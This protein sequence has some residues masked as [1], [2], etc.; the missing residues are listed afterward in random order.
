MKKLIIILM[1]FFFTACAGFQVAKQSFKDKS[2]WCH[3]EKYIIQVPE[4]INVK[5]WED[6]EETKKYGYMKKRIAS[7]LIVEYVYRRD[8]KVGYTFFEKEYG[9]KPFA[10]IIDW[11]DENGKTQ[12]EFWWYDDVKKPPVKINDDEFHRRFKVIEKQ[13]FDNY[14]ENARKT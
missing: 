8:G 6:P 13:D 11:D 5:A 3:G 1:C 12:A 14:G 2:W 4:K 9:C 7:S 10:L